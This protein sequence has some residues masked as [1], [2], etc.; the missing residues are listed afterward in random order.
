MKRALNIS[1]HAIFWLWNIAFLLIVYAGILP[2]VGK[3]L[4]AAAWSGELP[5]EF[6][7][8]F[9]ALIAVPTVSTVVGIWRFRKQPLQLLR[10]FYGVEAPLFL[11]C[12][13]RLFLLREL[14]PASSQIVGTLVLCIT[15]FCLD[16]L[17]G[18]I[19][20]R[21]G[22]STTYRRPLTWLQLGCHSLMVLVSLYAGAV[23]LFYALP[24]AWI[25]VREFVKFGWLQALIEMLTRSDLALDWWIPLGFLLF[26]F[27]LTLFLVMPSAFTALYLYSGRRIWKAFAAEYGKNRAIAGSATV[28]VAWL[29]IFLLVQQQP[30]TKAFA[31]LNNPAQTDSTRQSLLAKSSTIR[32][33]LLNAYLS[34]Y[35]YLSNRQ[36]NNHIQAMYNSVFGL[37]DAEGQILQGIYNQLMSPFL[38]NG[39]RNDSE[40]AAKLYAEFFDAPIQKSE[41]QAIQ[42]ALQSTANRD[43]AKA[44]LL[45]V[46]QKKVWLRSQNITLKPQ[47]DWAEVE[48]HEVYDNQTTNLQE[49]FYSF[50]LPESAVIT[51][52]WLGDT[53]NRSKRFPFQVSPR[54]AAQSVYNEQVRERV[55][56]A[57]LE[58]VGPRQYRLRAFPIPPKPSALNTNTTP[59]QPTEMHLWLTYQVMQQEAGWAL[60]QLAEKRNIFWTKNTQRLYNGKAVSS[61]EDWLPAFLPAQGKPQP[62]LHQANFPNGYRIWAKP[63]TAQDNTLPQGKRF[64]VVL[65]RSRSMA[66]HTQELKQT[67]QWLQDKGFADNNF[68]NNDADLYLTAS[69]GAQPQRIDDIRRFDVTK[70]TFYGTL[71]PQEILQQF[72]QLRSD[73]AYD[74]VLVVTDEGSYELSEDKTDI[75]A[76][77]A[78][79]WMVHIG[80]KL[81]SAY[82]DATLRTIQDSQGG[83]STA[84][85]EV[86]QRLATQAVQGDSVVSVVDGYAWSMEKQPQEVTVPANATSN[87]G[88]E[89]LAARQ[90]VMGLSQEKVEEKLAQLD[91]MHAVAKSSKIVTPYSSMIVLVNDQQREALKK[92]EQQADRFNREVEDGKEQLTQPFNPFEVS[93]V[94]EPEEW[95]LL[96]IVAIALV[97]LRQRQQSP[98]S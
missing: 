46:N 29:A 20:Q 67:F 3:P 69:P 37:P 31:L 1:F 73:T 63:L 95:M 38:Y 6:F 14:T 15:A 71:Q 11:L 48:L 13:I 96:G 2:I 84:I 47:G 25:V 16:L 86:M 51:G 30:Q 68:V 33:G 55:D 23:L 94:P 82:N 90:L 89:P 64:A 7:V 27:S 39:S 70:T 56:P 19:G 10:L 42:H 44:G 87:A 49:V 50:S 83:V 8:T 97:L 26:C 5:T 21:Q 32:T 60:P 62:S 74:A 54:G 36:E 24:L 35:R 52:L 79:L 18:Y 58:Q 65:D 61:S 12:L 22:I 72:A 34:S 9:I 4:M 75:P 66:S 98:I 45:N 93:G 76:I 57:L 78:P 43:E 81:P 53:D 91:T 80:G 28:V 92:A 59:N 85:S 41:Q 17:Y 40:K 77:T 88:F